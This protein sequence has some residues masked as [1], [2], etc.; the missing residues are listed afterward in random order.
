[1]SWITAERD[2]H[3]PCARSSVRWVL[4]SQQWQ[5]DGGRCQDHGLL[6]QSSKKMLW[7]SFQSQVRCHCMQNSVS[8][9]KLATSSTFQ[10]CSSKKYHVGAL[11]SKHI[12]RKLKV[13]LINFLIFI[14]RF[15]ASLMFPFPRIVATSTFESRFSIREI[16]KSPDWISKWIASSHSKWRG[17]E[18]IG[19][20]GPRLLHRTQ[21]FSRTELCRTTSIGRL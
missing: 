5:V 9:T 12:F 16:T 1:M 19:S 21:S 6:S 13:T 14:F 10:G 2:S 3:L 7:L 18:A 8:A 15:T 20:T 17:Q 4:Q 11:Q